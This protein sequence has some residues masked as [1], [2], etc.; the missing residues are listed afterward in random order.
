MTDDASRA[1]ATVRSTAIDGRLHNIYWRQDQLRSLHSTLVS[2][3]AAVLEATTRDSHN[4]LAEAKTEFYLTLAAVKQHFLSLSPKLEL[5]REYS[6]AHGKDAADRRDPV[7]I[8]YIEPQTSSSSAHTLFYSVIVPLASAIAAGNCVVVQLET[9]LQT[10]PPVIRQ[11]LSTALDQDIFAIVPTRPPSSFFATS[12]VISVLQ[13]GSE[14]ALSS[15]SST[16]TSASLISPAAARAVALVERNADL[17]AAA[18]ALVT[19]RFGFGGRSPYAP[20]VVLVNEFAKEAFLN[21]V[22]QESIKY[23][24]VAGEKSNGAAVNGRVGDGRG[25]GGGVSVVEQLKNEAGVR[26]VTAGANGAILDVEKRESTALG[27]KI[28]ERCLLVHATTSLDDGIDLT[29]KIAGNAPLATYL[30]ADPASCKYMSQFTT[31]HLSFANHFPLDLLV[32]PAA[33]TTAALDTT[34]RYP[35]SLFTVPR[36]QYAKP[37][38]L[39]ARLSGILQVAPGASSNSEALKS[40]KTEATTALPPNRP[41]KK[42]IGFFEQGILLGLGM[43]ALPLLSGLSLLT[44]YGSKTLLTYWRG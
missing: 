29:N 44:W 11:L 34:N 36:P 7:G 12:N 6:V 8:V 31:A 19:A 40:L 20:D 42:N 24:A 37:S 14:Q 2:H 32:G 43:T 35:S 25:K 26:V 3:E 17:G 27:R 28:G 41:Y 16:S 13:S 5:E 39:S 10:L 38:P 9:T 33:P 1:L 22:V 21:A 30:F 23:M 15:I 4:T 18:R